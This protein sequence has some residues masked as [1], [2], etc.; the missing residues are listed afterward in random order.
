MEAVLDRLFADPGVERVV[1]EPDARNHKIHVLNA[2]LGFQPAGEV[3][4][5]GQDRPCSASAPGRPSIPPAQTS[6][7]PRSAREHRYDHR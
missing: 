3:A 1:V 5:P 2:R 6:I 7:H 4:L